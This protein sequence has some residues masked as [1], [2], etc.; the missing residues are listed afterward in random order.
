M[1]AT[2]VAHIETADLPYYG[3]LCRA[4]AYFKS[5]EKQSRQIHLIALQKHCDYL[6]ALANMCPRNFADRAALAAAE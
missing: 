2:S 3:A 1:L 6:Q 5:T 4:A